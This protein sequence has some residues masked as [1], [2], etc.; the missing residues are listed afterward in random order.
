MSYIQVCIQI[1]KHPKNYFLLSCFSYMQIVVCIFSD[2]FFDYS[3]F[4]A[5]SIKY[6]TIFGHTLIITISDVK[7]NSYI[8]I[9]NFVF[10]NLRIYSSISLNFFNFKER[11]G[12]Y[13]LTVAHD[14]NKNDG[15]YNE[16]VAVVNGIR[17]AA[18]AQKT[19]DLNSF[20]QMPTLLLLLAKW[21]TNQFLNVSLCQGP[22]TFLNKLSID[23]RL[24]RG[25]MRMRTR[26]RTWE[27]NCSEQGF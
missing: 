22:W 4:I 24:R 3:L 7:S 12:E 17:K 14:K 23:K 13:F 1:F 8:Y 18:V 16:L 20:H 26:I 19:N 15:R 6:V 11:F 21:K 10:R 5:F 27:W 9:I 25:R 2:Y